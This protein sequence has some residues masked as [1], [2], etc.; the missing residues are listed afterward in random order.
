[1]TNP[2][3]P[4]PVAPRKA[5]RPRATPE[6]IRETSEARLLS[7]TQIGSI[8]E[9][10]PTTCG[11]LYWPAPAPQYRKSVR[12]QAFMWLTDHEGIELHPLVRVRRMCKTQNC[13]NPAHLT[14]Q[15]VSLGDKAIPLPPF[16]KLVNVDWWVAA[17]DKKRS[18][19]ISIHN[20]LFPDDRRESPSAF[21][22]AR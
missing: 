21:P 22:R 1:M 20:C 4:P 5:G 18:D 15:H 11:A 9:C 3:A 7:K 12:P 16:G 6:Q 8:N 2:F 13:V 10:W 19:W 17:D 14:T